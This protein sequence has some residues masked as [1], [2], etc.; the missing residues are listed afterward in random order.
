MIDSVHRLASVW[1]WWWWGL[2]KWR[3]N[4]VNY[5]KVIL[6]SLIPRTVRIFLSSLFIRNSQL[7]E[8]KSFVLKF[9]SSP[10]GGNAIPFWIGNTYSAAGLSGV[11]TWRVTL[12]LAFRMKLWILLFC[13]G[14]SWRLWASVMTQPL[15]NRN[16][17]SIYLLP[18]LSSISIRQTTFIF[19]LCSSIRLWNWINE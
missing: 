8:S 10:A 4:L 13:S 12:Y 15:P 1:L 19:F 11:W 2:N 18:C 17:V 9:T 6:L 16:P 3:C 7:H 5:I 14:P